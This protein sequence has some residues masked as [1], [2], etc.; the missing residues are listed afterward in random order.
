MSSETQFTIAQV[1]DEIKEMLIAKINL[2]V[3]L[4]LILLGFFLHQIA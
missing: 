4:P 1:C 2:M 3:T